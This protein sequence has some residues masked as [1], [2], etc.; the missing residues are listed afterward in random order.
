M[1]KYTVLLQRPD[2]VADQYGADTYMAWVRAVSVEKAI[3]V[4]QKE[5]VEFDDREDSADPIDYYPLA[6]FEGHLYDIKAGY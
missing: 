6:V 3:K 4:A 5:A 1:K 2:Y